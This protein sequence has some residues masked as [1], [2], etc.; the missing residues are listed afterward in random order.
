M[1]EKE[2]GQVIQPR[3]VPV[4]CH[5]LEVD[6][7][8]KRRDNSHWCVDC[9]GYLGTPGR[10]GRMLE[11]PEPCDCELTEVERRTH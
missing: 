3:A 8:V 5:C 1:A 6:E 9:G 11:H 10:D 4:V 2:K 7:M